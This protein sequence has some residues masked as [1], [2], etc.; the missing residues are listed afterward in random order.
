MKEK[1]EMEKI[2]EEAKEF[3]KKFMEKAD[4]KTRK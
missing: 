1:E 4:E 2:I 3:E